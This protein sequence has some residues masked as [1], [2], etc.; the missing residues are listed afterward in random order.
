MNEVHFAPSESHQ[1]TKSWISFNYLIRATPWFTVSVLVNKHC[2]VLTRVVSVSTRN[3]A[4]SQKH[5]GDTQAVSPGEIFFVL[6]HMTEHFSQASKTFFFLLIDVH[7]YNSYYTNYSDSKYPGK[8]FSYTIKI[9]L[10]WRNFIYFKLNFFPVF[11][12]SAVWKKKQSN[13]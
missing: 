7:C 2:Q 12:I 8:G 6:L 13:L 11:S 1:Q 9:L 5:L 3:I 4:A 10:F